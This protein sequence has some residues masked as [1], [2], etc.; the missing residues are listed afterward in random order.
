MDGT[1]STAGEVVRIKLRVPHLPPGLVTRTRL[2]DPLRHGAAPVTLVCAPAGFGKTVM[3]LDWVREEGGPVAW[4]SLDRLDNDPR[5]FFLHLAEAVEGLELPGARQAARLIRGEAGSSGDSALAELLILLGELE[6]RAMLVLDDLHEIETG[7]VLDYLARLLAHYDRGPRLFLLTRRDLPLPLARLRLEGRLTEFRE[8][9]LRFSREE[10]SRLFEGLLPH[11]LDA[12]LVERLETRTEGWAA[13][14]RMAALM[15]Q[16]AENAASAVDAFTG[17]NRFVVEYLLEEVLG[18][19]GPAIQRFLLETSIL[20]RFTGDAC[21]IVTADPSARETLH[22]VEEAGLLLVPLGGSPAWFRYH[23]LFAELLHFRLRRLHPERLDGLHERASG[24]FEAEGDV[25]EAMEQAARI[26]SKTL[27]VQLLDRHGMAIIARS[28]VGVLHRWLEQVPDLLAH[29]FPTFLLILGWI[30]LHT[31]KEPDLA[32]LLRA[33]YLAVENPAVPYSEADRTRAKVALDTLRAYVARY[34][35]RLE[36]AL[37]L[38]EGALAATETSDAV[39]RGMLHYNQARVF[40]TQGDMDAAQVHLEKSIA[41]N[42]EAGTT[43]LVLNGLA[44]R[45]AVH[46]Q[47]HGLIRAREALASAI[48]HAERN[49]IHRLPAFASLLYQL[50]RVHL[51]A[52][53]LDAAETHFDR[54]LNHGGPGG[55]YEARYRGLMGLACVRTAQRRYDEARA[56]LDETEVFLETHEESVFALDTTLELERRRLALFLGTAGLG[57]PVVLPEPSADAGPWTTCLETDLLLRLQAALQLASDQD[58]ARALARHI[59]EE[60]RPRQRGVAEIAA[61]MA[62]AV[63]ADGSDAFPLLEDTMEAAAVRGYVRPIIDLGE[64]ARALLQSSLS[65]RLRPAAR[66][67]ARHLL[68]RFEARDLASAHPPAQAPVSAAGGTSQRDIL[69]DREQEV[70]AELC[71]GG[72]YKSIAR[73]LYISPETVRTHLKHVYAKLGVK[74]KREAIGRA[75]QMGLAGDGVA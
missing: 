73:T 23:H 8:G 38:C 29:R 12:G 1:E 15:L 67:H 65:R 33:A 3:V 74:K 13:G 21:A 27:L 54:A 75:R 49:Q 6:G 28:E 35:G 47:T 48:E 64:P 56:L 71:H 59:E 5:R 9:D 66:I 30:R 58:R 46:A 41:S 69:T 7:P 45:G 20:P 37:S 42:R 22:E 62:G 14:L 53:D 17:S 34:R 60:S 25:Y 50:G 61:R 72:T 36:E 11:G 55:F 24:W 18:G 51:L 2:F 40:M 68:D 4:F 52:D 26:S 70:L 43:Y 63:L 57:P 16:R 44:H 31:E 39:A 32:E 10:A 19:Q